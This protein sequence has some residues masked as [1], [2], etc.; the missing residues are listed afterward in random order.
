[1][2][3]DIILQVQYYEENWHEVD[4][5]DDLTRAARQGIESEE[6]VIELIDVMIETLKSY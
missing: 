2:P 5:R 4:I 6:E 3:F 1:M